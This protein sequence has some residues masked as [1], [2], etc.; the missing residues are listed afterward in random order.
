MSLKVEFID[1]SSSQYDQNAARISLSPLPALDS[2][3]SSIST[4]TGN[5]K[6]TSTKQQGPLY[7]GDKDSLSFVQIKA[8]SIQ[9]VLCCSADLAGY[10]K[11]PGVD[12][13]KIDA[14]QYSLPSSSSG[15]TSGGLSKKA[16]EA[17]EQMIS[18]L[19]QFLEKHLRQG[20][21]VLVCCESGFRSSIL[22]TTAFFMKTYGYSLEDSVTRIERV[23]GKNKFTLSQCKIALDIE[24]K[25]L[26]KNSMKLEGKQLSSL[27]SNSNSSSSFS[28]MEKE[29][30]RQ[31]HSV[32]S[33]NDSQ[34]KKSTNNNSSSVSGTKI[35]LGVGLFF[36]I[37]FGV[38]Y[39]VTGKV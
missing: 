18:Q 36:G 24:K 1:N 27:S 20:H 7:V 17:N 21:N 19:A 13:M 39:A 12:Y 38:L 16:R 35:L 3:S 5:K 29:K 6:S 22:F 11:E 14:E 8:R 2:S 25:I 4:N 37:V 9:A 28:P 10:C 15:S 31:N 34:G 23:R 32:D 33:D 26:G 30:S